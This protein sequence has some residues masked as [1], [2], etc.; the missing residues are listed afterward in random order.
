MRTEYTR[1]KCS[2]SS[3][4]E[5]KRRDNQIEGR[6]EEGSDTGER[7]RDRE[8][9]WSCGGCKQGDDRYEFPGIPVSPG[10]PVQIAITV[11]IYVKACG[12]ELDDISSNPL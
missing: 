6:E 9:V 2:R 11:L 8:W 1:G 7:K 4:R 3:E 10:Y 12:E 5:R